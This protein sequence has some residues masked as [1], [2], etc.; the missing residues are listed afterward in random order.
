MEVEALGSRYFI[1]CLRNIL[2]YFFFNTY[3]YLGDTMDIDLQKV[4]K[5]IKNN[6]NKSEKNDSKGTSIYNFFI[7]V[8]I[9]I[10]L[11]LITLIVLKN[12][13]KL[14]ATF[15][16]HVY[17]DNISF[18]TI[19]NL[20]EKYF[21]SAIPFKNLLDKKTE[22]VFNEKLKYTNSS[23]YLD[24]VQLE[25]SDNYLVPISESGM[26]VFIGEKEGYGNTVIIQQMDGIDVWYG[27]VKNVNVKLYE[28][29]EAGKL[30]AEADKKLYLVYKKNGNVLNYEDY[31]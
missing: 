20:Y 2:I 7:R 28:Y 1:Y 14:K 19:N 24:G 3:N 22:Q 5:E 25:V 18:T 13:T 29:V 9:T 30:L 16:K 12:N 17:E 21:G 6:K 23:K 4:R 10:I 15:Y 8:M 11:V 27:N 26:V 31:I